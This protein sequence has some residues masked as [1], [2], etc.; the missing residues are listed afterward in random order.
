MLSSASGANTK[1]STATATPACRSWEAVLVFSAVICYP[2]STKT[3]NI[4]KR[5]QPVV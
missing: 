2:S 3:V 1:G 5:T 4:R